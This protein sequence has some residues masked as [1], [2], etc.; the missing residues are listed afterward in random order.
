[1]CG[2]F[3]V[4]YGTPAQGERAKED[5][6]SLFRLS[7]SRGKESAGVAVQTKEKVEIYK[8]P[9][10]ATQFVKK[11]EFVET[12]SHDS[13]H[14]FI[15]HA[16]LVT[17]GDETKNYNNQPV[18]KD[19][20]VGVHNGIIVNDDELWT[21]NA[22]SKRKYDVDTEVLLS[23]IR[24]EH[25]RGASLLGA[26]GAMYEKVYGTA[27]LALYMED[28]PYLL[29]TTN[30]GSLYV[31]HDKSQK[32][33]YFASERYILNTFLQHSNAGQAASVQTVHVEPGS[34][35]AV[36]LQTKEAVPFRYDTAQH[37][38]LTDTAHITLVDSSQQ[39]VDGV[40][41]P[42][43]TADFQQVPKLDDVR[44]AIGA[45][46]RCSRCILPETMPFIEFD[47]A[48]VCNYCHAYVKQK[49]EGKDALAK[50]LKSESEGE[51]PS[52]LFALSGGRDSSY[53]LHYLVQEMGV[54]PVTYSY[55]W[56]MITDL[57]RRNQARMCG[58]L[59][60]ENILVSA[61]I[62]FKRSN[63]RKN[64]NAWFKKPEIGMI[65]LFM[66]GDKQFFYH[67]NKLKKQLGAQKVVF[68]QNPYEITHF[69]TGYAGVP[70][71]LTKDENLYYHSLSL[72]KKTKFMSFYT[73]N[74]ITNP[75]YINLSILDTLLAYASF[76]V[77]PHDYVFLYHYIQWD[78]DEINKVLLDTYKWELAPDT[79]TTW[80]I[81]DGTA[82]F[83]NYIYYVVTG[84]TENDTFR[85]NQ[86]RE[87]VLK[88]DTALALSAKENE[89]RYESMK[90]YCD[91]VGIEFLD[92]LRQIHEM[93][94]LY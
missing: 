64:I 8:E 87:G 61:N 86:V 55:D 45:L 39:V 31:A 46:R 18:M 9:T 56:G 40:Q 68:S 1:M 59:G 60:I 53:G 25:K 15:G 7:E 23:L 29:L 37:P 93:P 57:A 85:S 54:R 58:K 41:Q 81:G 66:A 44:D 47:D 84:F 72:L 42:K 11:R 79:D 4:V 6:S 22:L 5:A 30:N 71:T 52:C 19:G 14:S 20:M 2:I 82:P 17:N 34:G 90:W 89:P 62:P 76:Y 36:H 32:N 80:R 51:A 70:P 33:T 94:R 69:K 67:A 48:G 3:G 92:A 13:V 77:I 88:R 63:I 26:L 27:S 43:H 74:Y 78:E 38:G 21:S 24:A 10:R 91:T 16:R 12:F 75:S 49:L 73:R 50:V 35:F 28:A 65:P 83:Y